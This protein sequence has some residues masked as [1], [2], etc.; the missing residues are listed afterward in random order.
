M[1]QLQEQGDVVA[2]I[3][4]PQQIVDEFV[5]PTTAIVPVVDA[6]ASVTDTTAL[7]VGDNLT[8][9]SPKAAFADCEFAVALDID[10]V[11]LCGKE[12]IESSVETLTVLRKLKVP[13][14]L[15]TNGGGTTE[16]AQADRLASRVNVPIEADQFVQSHTPFLDFIDEYKEDFVLVLG[17]Y[18]DHVRNL[19][20]AY[21][22]DADKV[23]TDSDLLIHYPYLNAFSE[24]TGGYH[25]DFGRFNKSFAEKPIIGAIFIF[26]SPRDWGLDLQIC[27][28]L[29]L[30]EG[31]KID[32]RS[33]MN[34]N[35]L[36]C[37]KGF[38]QDDQ[39]SIFFCNL[40]LEWATPHVQPRFAQGAF[41]ACLDGLWNAYTGGHTPLQAWHCGKPT[42]TT[43]R[44]AERVIHAYHDKLYPQ[45]TAMVKHAYMIGD[46]PASDVQGAETANAS[47]GCDMEWR[48]ALVKTGVYQERAGLLPTPFPTRVCNDV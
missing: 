29:L 6:I 37:N 24:V 7:P 32:T 13:F 44:Y 9:Q 26:S 39:P 31:G 25:S 30:S 17:G 12:A 18:G 10:G 46:N 2:V 4:S 16:A 3:A 27:M 1:V 28:D 11:L 48:S 40:D 35:P 23:I 21:G 5:V 41:R 38:Q 20:I 14:I 47:E 19:A 45:S 42:E 33:T 36:L 22:L 43:Y 15:L 8:L 34:G